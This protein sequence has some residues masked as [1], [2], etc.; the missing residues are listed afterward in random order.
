MWQFQEIYKVCL[1]VVQNGSDRCVGEVFHHRYSRKQQMKGEGDHS[2]ELRG[3]L[4]YIAIWLSQ[5]L[6]KCRSETSTQ[7]IEVNDRLFPQLFYYA[8]SLVTK[9]ENVTFFG[10]S[11]LLITQ[12][13][14]TRSVFLTRASLMPPGSSLTN[15]RSSE[16]SVSFFQSLKRLQLI[17]PAIW[18]RSLKAKGRFCS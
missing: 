16:R 6:R 18:P 13:G 17:P 11:L 10:K 5:H 1:N 4:S 3:N 9:A 15:W 12:E 7:I 2:L 8:F 14:N